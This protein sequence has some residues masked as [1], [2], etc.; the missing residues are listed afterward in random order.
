MANQNESKVMQA[1]PVSALDR[2]LEELT[3]ASAMPSSYKASAPQQGGLGAYIARNLR[4]RVV[5]AGAAALI[6][7]FAG[8]KY[9]GNFKESYNAAKAYAGSCFNTGVKTAFNALPEQQKYEI[10]RE[11]ARKMKPAELMNK[12]N[13]LSREMDYQP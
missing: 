11:N 2:R 10:I 8:G 4:S 13:S 12:I 1:S 3:R 6:G 9:Y 5:L 7:F